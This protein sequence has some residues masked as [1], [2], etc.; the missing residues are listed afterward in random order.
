MGSIPVCGNF[1]LFVD[2]FLLFLYFCVFARVFEQAEFREGERRKRDTAG[3]TESCACRPLQRSYIHRG[4]HG[5]VSASRGGAVVSTLLT[6]NLPECLALGPRQFETRNRSALWLAAQ[7]ILA[8]IV[9]H[10]SGRVVAETLVQI[11][12]AA[13]HFFFFHS[14]R[15]DT[16][17]GCLAACVP[18]IYHSLVPNLASKKPLWCNGNTLSRYNLPG[19]RRD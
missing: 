12:F 2:L 4:V 10:R 15:S 6:H 16:F 7:S 1:Y 17:L 18:P 19:D 5:F 8:T 13:I 3:K 11:Q 14:L 9:G